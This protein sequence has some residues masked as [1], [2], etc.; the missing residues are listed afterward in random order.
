MTVKNNRADPK[1]L[2]HA[3]TLIGTKEYPGKPSNPVIMTWA[4]KLAKFLGIKYTDDSIPWCGLFVTECMVEVG[5]MPPK[6]P[7]RAS[8]WAKWGQPLKNPVP[9]AVL[10]FTRNGG[11]HVGFYVSEDYKYFHVLGGNQ[12]DAVNIA[13]I[14]KDRLT[15][16]RWP[17]SQPVQGEAVYTI[18]TIAV[19][20]NEA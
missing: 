6:V 18:S 19:S 16:I 5:I 3:R 8:S 9:G 1:W 13:K 4:K 10:V 15:A 20:K 11:G 12:S 2:A 7:V 17:E 14:A